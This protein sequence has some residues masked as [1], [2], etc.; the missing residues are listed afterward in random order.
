[1]FVPFVRFGPRRRAGMVTWV[2]TMSLR[3]RILLL[4]AI[5][6]LALLLNLFILANMST[7]FANSLGQI[8]REG[9]GKQ[10]ITIKLELHLRAMETSLHRFMRSGNPT[11][12]EQFRYHIA[13][14]RSYVRQYEAVADDEAE[15]QRSATLYEDT[16][17]IEGLVEQVDFHR[18]RRQ[19]LEREL[20]AAFEAFGAVLDEL[21]LQVGLENDTR[22][23]QSISGVDGAAHDLML[24]VIAYAEY[25]TDER[26]VAVDRADRLFAERVTSLRREA[27][28]R[29]VQPLT[30]EVERRAITLRRLARQV[31]EHA[32]A[33][34]AAFG[35]LEKTTV[36]VEQ[37]IQE[38]RVDAVRGTEEARRTFER[39]LTRTWRAGL[40]VSLGAVIIG[41]LSSGLL[42]WRL[43][44]TV[45]HVVE[46]LEHIEAGDFSR[47]IELDSNDELGRIARA[48]NQVM[49]E[50][51]RQRAELE[52]WGTLLETRIAERTEKLQRA[53][54]EINA[55]YT[56]SQ[57]LSAVMEL[58]QVLHV[59]YQELQELV[60]FD[61]FYIAL[62]DQAAD[63]VHAALY[64]ERG[65][66]LSPLTFKL[67]EAGLAGWIIRTGRS[68]FVRNMEEER[69]RLP[70]TPRRV[71]R[72]FGASCYFG[73]PLQVHGRTIG[74]LSVQRELEHGGPFDEE[75]RRFV[76]ALAGHVA[77]AVENARL[78]QALLEAA[79]TDPLTG[80]HNRRHFEQ[81]LKV[82]VERARR[83]RWPL[84]LVMC[85]VD[86]LKR[87]NDTFGHACGDRLLVAMAE[88]LRRAARQTDVLARWGGD[89][90]VV[91]LPDADEQGARHFVQR[92]HQMAPDHAIRCADTTIPLIFSA[93]VATLHS[94]HHNGEGLLR[95]ADAAMY[96]A[97]VR[98]RK[99]QA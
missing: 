35:D 90:F 68:L 11:D 79:Q 49:D 8:T 1:M 46:T 37:L 86:G 74:V 60:R 93:G 77:V 85:D 80:L 53:L 72:P 96:E 65:E 47:R 87:V 6:S 89:E 44:T 75:E 56:L 13:L 57:K 7:T 48:F 43:H 34:E 54:E 9:L 63:E 83:H 45:S 50:V 38:A 28:G 30:A 39:S 42:L 12:M 16:E 26:R 78:Y 66:V 70:A 76:M 88:L 14:F 73:V 55:L 4:F 99:D 27:V 24:A 69:D 64:V 25:P 52:K 20:T 82:E 29:D 62:Y 41:L 18:R 67:D 23:L 22:S 40:A 81:Q 97:K 84:S 2:F 91:L 5:L 10:L 58:D 94:P 19:E 95:T 15:R 61:V 17:R 21:F 31:I 33:R 36:Y 71:G 51:V 3:D 98:R 92:L 59:V 32:D